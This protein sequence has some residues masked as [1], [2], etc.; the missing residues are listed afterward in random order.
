MQD[1]DH[2][3]FIEVR[4]R[5]NSLFGSAAE[6]IDAEKRRRI[7]F[8]AQHYLQSRRIQPPVRFDVVA[9][10]ANRE[11]QWIIDAFDAD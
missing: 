10:H 4:Y 5:N 8:S 2:L 1:A 7:V 3:V 9:L 11:P 6:S